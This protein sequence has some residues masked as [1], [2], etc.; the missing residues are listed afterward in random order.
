MSLTVMVGTLPAWRASTAASGGQRS[1]E[2]E[3]RK[4]TQW[5]S[6]ATNQPRRGRIGCTGCCQAIA[7]MVNIVMG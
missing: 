1:P 6:I 3:L 7:I 2:A 5:A 4:G